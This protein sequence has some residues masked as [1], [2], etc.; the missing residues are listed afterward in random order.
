MNYTEFAKKIKT[1]YPDY[2]DVDDRELAERVVAKYPDYK[3]VVEF[4][5]QED[6]SMAGSFARGAMSGIP[7][8]TAAVSGIQAIGDKTYEEAHKDL[9][10]A[11]D[12][13][14]KENPISYGTGKAAGMIGTAFAA[15]AS[16]PAAIGMGALSGLDAA[17]NLEDMPM[18]AVKG[19]GIGAVLGK[20][21]QVLGDKVIAPIVN[22][23]LPRVSKQILASM[24][25][26]TKLEHIEAY[27]KNPEAIR[28]A[29]SK[30]EIGEEIAHTA[31]DLGK[32]SGRMSHESRGM[33][34]QDVKPLSVSPVPVA[35]QSTGLVSES[36]KEIMKS[37]EPVVAKPDTV[38]PIFDNLIKRFTQDGVAPTGERAAAVQTL[39]SQYKRL[40]DIARVNGDELS[41]KSLREYIDALQDTVN[42]KAW[43]DPE[44]MESQNAI[45]QLSGELRKV[46]VNSNPEYAQA[47]APSAEAVGM[48]DDLSRTFKLDSGD[49][50]DATFTKVGN[51]L[52]DG[53]TEGMAALE[54]L[55]GLTGK[56]FVKALQDSD[57]KAAFEASGSGPALKTL[58][59]SLGFGIGKMTGIPFGG[60][61]GAAVGRY[62]AEG[63]NGAAVAKKVLDAYIGNKNMWAKSSTRALVQK[64]GPI[65]ANA[66]K[67]GGN[68]LAATHFVLAT[69]DPEYQQLSGDIQDNQ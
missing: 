63:M 16:I 55:K 44:V 35:P 21:G 15:P 8:A 37:V 51:V 65:L 58:M 25:G 18:D 22:N 19:A 4:D 10:T 26:K 59:A 5:A 48:A 41:E 60:I 54:K 9:E 68:Q 61:G 57:V 6:P 69:S 27:L 64:Y 52:K 36:G 30:A 11:K 13:D 1:K 23:V 50:T 28:K 17:T 20:G 38:R 45:K 62:M 66:A 7:G 2:Q 33:L 12:A 29:M 14:W 46:L 32:A 67:V 49:A 47:M 53:K 31:D 39:E 24:G 56:D 34:S 3:D 42:K 43:G 40:V